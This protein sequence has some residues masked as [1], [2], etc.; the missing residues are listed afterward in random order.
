M[1]EMFVSEQKKDV[2]ER[3]EREALKIVLFGS[4]EL[5]IPELTD[6]GEITEPSDLGNLDSFSII[7]LILALEDA[8]GVPLLDDMA[9]FGG[10]NFDD[11]ADF[12]VE[13]LPGRA[14]GQG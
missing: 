10:K 5:A 14:D 11:L 13:R 1:T 8:Y 4:D 7:L 12:V 2:R 9:G 3:I 6:L